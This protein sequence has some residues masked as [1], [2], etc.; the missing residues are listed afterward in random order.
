MTLGSYYLHRTGSTEPLAILESP[1]PLVLMILMTIDQNIIL[2]L[3]LSS[4]MVL[5]YTCFSGSFPFL[6]SHSPTLREIP[7][8][9]HNPARI[10]SGQLLNS[11]C[12]NI[13]HPCTVELGRTIP[14]NN[15]AP[16]VF[17][18][19]DYH[20]TINQRRVSGER[21]CPFM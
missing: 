12:I 16:S 3:P 8:L 13:L 18:H 21:N 17:L 7:T 6:L 11:R 15:A 5:G 4:A 19:D 1:Y 2:T 9:R 14:T 10:V 20:P